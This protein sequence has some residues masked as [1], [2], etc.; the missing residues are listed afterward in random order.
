MRNLIYI[1]V[2]QKKIAVTIK[3][4]ETSLNSI[5]LDLDTKNLIR[6]KAVNIINSNSK[7]SQH[8]RKHQRESIN[9]FLYTKTIFERKS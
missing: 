1:I 2:F 6:Q 8:L 4:L 7:S 9:N 3:N 5:K